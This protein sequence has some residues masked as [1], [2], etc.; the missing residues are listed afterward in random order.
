MAVIFVGETDTGFQTNHWQVPPEPALM[1]SPI[2]RGYRIYRGTLPVLALGA[3]DETQVDIG[4]TFPTGYVYLPR[5][6]TIE[7]ISD[8]LTT[9][10]SNNGQL[11]YRPGGGAGLATTHSYALECPGAS[12]RAAARSVQVYHPVGTWKHFIRP[13][14]GDLIHLWLAD[15]SGDTSAAGDVLWHAEFLEY[16]VEQ[17]LRWE[18]NSPNPVYNF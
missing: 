5:Q 1:A 2:P 4:M 15:I 3:G 7:F 9:E 17:L 11:E 8:D 12:F 14:D 10:F 18:V 6:L 13:E 16:D